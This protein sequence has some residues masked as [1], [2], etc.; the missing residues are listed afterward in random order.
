MPSKRKKQSQLPRF[1]LSFVGSAFEDAKQVPV[2]MRAQLTSILERL[3]KE[4]CR[5][6]AYALSGPP[7]WPHLCAVHFDGWRVVVAF[8]ADDEVTIVK[9]AKHDPDTDPYRE[10]AGELELPISTAERTKP[11]CCDPDGEPPVNPQ[12]VEDVS[13]AFKALTR[14]QRRER[15]RRV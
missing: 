10:L 6:A 8:P 14:R 15:S 5:A 2:K 13:A 11:P 1:T 12:L 9:I 4:G 3:S 7:P